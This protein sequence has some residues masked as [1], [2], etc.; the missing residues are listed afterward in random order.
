MSEIEKTFA[1]RAN[2][3]TSLPTAIDALFEAVQTMGFPRL[4]YAYMPVPRRGDGKWLSPPVTVRNYPAGWDRQWEHHCPND[5]YFHACF[6][7]TLS[8]EWNQVQSRTNLT[9]NERD[10]GP[11]LP[12]QA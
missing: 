9:D 7:S 2:R 5:P 4:A 6:E 8:V 1:D 12:K 11:I 3:A 10:S